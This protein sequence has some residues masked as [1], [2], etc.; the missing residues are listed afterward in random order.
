MERIDSYCTNSPL[1]LMSMHIF[2]AINLQDKVLLLYQ[3]LQ[4]RENLVSNLP[5]SVINNQ[6]RNCYC[7]DVPDFR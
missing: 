3:K 1:M 7:V 5:T 2:R 4:S 6:E